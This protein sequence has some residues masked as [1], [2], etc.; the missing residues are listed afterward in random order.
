MKKHSF[1]ED[2]S[3]P[4]L[5]IQN[6]GGVYEYGSN[7]D[8]L[9]ARGALALKSAERSPKDQREAG[10]A[11]RRDKSS[12]YGED[13]GGHLIGARFG[14]SGKAENL[15]AQDRNLNRGTFKNQENVWEEH[16]RQGDKVFVHIETDK[17]N[18]PNAYFGYAIYEKEDG[19]RIPDFFHYVNESRAEQDKWEQTEE[20]FDFSKRVSE[21]DMHA[22]NI[23]FL[24][25]G[26]TKMQDEREESVTSEQDNNVLQNKDNSLSLNL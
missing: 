15:T 1:L 20:E 24:P 18:R 22:E 9:Y 21:S 4:E 23:E 26:A 2:Y 6:K 5:F 25:K 11:F 10:G 16:L 14:G 19:T 8:A 17:G 3:N 12:P 7:D 13:D